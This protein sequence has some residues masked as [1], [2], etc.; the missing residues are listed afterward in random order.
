MLTQVRPY[1]LTTEAGRAL[2][3]KDS[4][5]ECANDCSEMIIV[6]A[7]DFMMGSP[8][9]EKGH[10]EDE[11]PRHKVI[12]AKPFAVSKFEVTFEQW[13]A[14][15][16]VGGC[17]QVPDSRGGRG[18]QPVINVNWHEA[19]QYV[20]WFSKMTG[21][22]YRLLSE[23]EWEYAAR[24]GTTTA[25]SWGDEIGKGNANCNGCGGRWDDRRLPAPVG[26]F[27]ANKFGLYDM[28]GNVSEWVEDCWHDNYLGN[29]PSDGSAWATGCP[30]ISRRVIRGGSWVNDPRFLRAAGRH[31]VTTD[32]RFNSLGF[33]V[34]RTLTP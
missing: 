11:G 4:F 24:A 25:Y 33:R 26:S 21:Q 8:K 13:D 7:G 22:T 14:C 34:G 3:A 6:P 2:K 19:R 9:E 1:V 31:W 16:A 27:A 32:G 17:A 30:D 10:Y 12:F 18:I 23:A 28:H 15:V 29:P 20:A 5:K